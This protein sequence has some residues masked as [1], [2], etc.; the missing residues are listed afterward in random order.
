MEQSEQP[1]LLASGH[2]RPIKTITGQLPAALLGVGF[3]WLAALGD[4]RDLHHFILWLL[5]LG[6]GS[7]S[8]GWVLYLIA[9]AFSG[10]PKI[11]LM[12]GWLIS[13]GLSKRTLH[14]NLSEYGKAEVVQFGRWTQTALAFHNLIEEAALAKA[15][16]AHSP[17]SLNAAKL[18]PLT[19][20]V[21]NDL[22]RAQEIADQINE[23]R[24]NY[25]EAVDLQG[26]N[27]ERIL[28][29]KMNSHI[30]GFL[31]TVGVS[32]FMAVVL[33]ILLPG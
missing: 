14:L 30:W 33:K 3:L 24:A 2:L 20:S 32:I 23:Y 18:F 1:I 9:C 25:I 15:G 28:S 22:Q 6:F 29:R 21:G 27:V 17:T 8:L 31:A 12:G 10:Y 4:W 16:L 5:L 13:F 26:V 19:Y 7:A 11:V